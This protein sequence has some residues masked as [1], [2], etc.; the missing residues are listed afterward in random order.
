ML[1]PI[2]MEKT[3]PMAW[4]LMPPFVHRIRNFSQ[5]FTVSGWDNAAPWFE[6]CFGAND[7]RMLGIAVVQEEGGKPEV[8]GHL[9]AGL[10]T[11]LGAPVG[12]VYQFSK[13]KG[14]SFIKARDDRDESGTAPFEMM[15]YMVQAWCRGHEVTQCYALV[16][17]AARTKLFGWFGFDDN[18][19]IV[20]MHIANHVQLADTG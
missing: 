14:K 19:R 1:T 3:N 15:H 8:V 17:G 9:L 12:M 4:Y 11:Y 10:E 6:T 16:E 7:P 13:D 18:M 2:I 5:S 20:R